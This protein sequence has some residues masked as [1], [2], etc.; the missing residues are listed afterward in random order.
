MIFQ[1]TIRI[2]GYARTVAAQDR[3]H[4]GRVPRL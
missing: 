2:L 1:V 4:P 3:G